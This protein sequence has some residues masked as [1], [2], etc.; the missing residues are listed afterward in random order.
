MK[1]QK[2]KPKVP[3][4]TLYP[5]ANADALDLLDKM[6]KFD[7]AERCSVEEA[8]AHPYMTGLHAPED[9]PVA[10]GQFDFAFESREL[11][12]VDIQQLIFKELVGFH[13]EAA[14]E[15]AAHVAANPPLAAASDSN[16]P[17]A[18]SQ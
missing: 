8:L 14:A 6:L 4:S 11:R 5:E 9:E 18:A 12:K 1:A 10:E 17:A 13:P 7:P 16:A 2:A 15:L 3:F